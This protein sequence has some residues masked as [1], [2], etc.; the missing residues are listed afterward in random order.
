VAKVDSQYIGRRPR[1]TCRSH[2][3]ISQDKYDTYRFSFVSRGKTFVL[4]SQ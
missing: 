3:I 1:L 2:K 4:N